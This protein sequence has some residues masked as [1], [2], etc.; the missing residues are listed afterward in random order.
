M[1]VTGLVPGDGKLKKVGGGSQCQLTWSP[2]EDFLYLIGHGGRQKNR[3]YRYNP[4]NAK[5][6][7]WL[8]LPGAYSHEYFPKLSNDGRYMVLAAS[9][10]ERGQHEHDTSD[11]E[12]F[13]W[14]VNEPAEQAMRITHDP[15]N[16]CWPDIWLKP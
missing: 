8:D 9:T 7:P 3:V 16:D 5:T 11:Y 14:R 2:G 1:R 6:T 4:A 10:G 12:V 13:L 15:A